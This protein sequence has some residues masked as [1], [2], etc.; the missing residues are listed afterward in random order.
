MKRSDLERLRETKDLGG[1]QAAIVEA[2]RIKIEK[3]KKERKRVML[4]R[5]LK[6][7]RT[8]KRRRRKELARKNGNH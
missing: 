6:K 4:K 1:E 5:E 7:K 2:Y 3:E 8:Q